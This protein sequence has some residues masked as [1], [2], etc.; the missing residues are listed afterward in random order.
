MPTG[1]PSST[2]SRGSYDIQVHDFSAVHNFHLSGPGVNLWTGVDEIIHPIW[3]LNLT[4]GTYRFACDSHATLKGSFTV[5]VRPPPIPARCRVPKVVGKTL[6][7]ARRT[8]RRSNCAVGRIRY[9]RS[10][11]PK[12][13]VVSQS[14]RGGLSL[15][16]GTK[17]NLVL[18][19]GASVSYATRV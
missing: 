15:P 12:G 2:C 14:R 16:R 4:T 11:R 17:V 5:G 9:T 1:G 8:I 7:V 18:S 3:T 10:K 6:A 19:K 13:R